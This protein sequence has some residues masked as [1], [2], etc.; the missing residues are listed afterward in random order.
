MDL[1]LHIS[2]F[3]SL[4]FSPKKPLAGSFGDLLMCMALSGD[5]WARLVQEERLCWPKKR[6]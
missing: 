2:V 3:A 1:H 4:I 5:S 6:V